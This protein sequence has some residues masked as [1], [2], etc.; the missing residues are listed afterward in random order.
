MK[1]KDEIV[2]V[3]LLYIVTLLYSYEKKNKQY[4][5]YT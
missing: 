3:K 2:Q 5:A 1:I 4:D